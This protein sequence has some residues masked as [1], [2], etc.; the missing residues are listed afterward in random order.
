LD[1]PDQARAALRNP[2][3]DKE[4]GVYAGSWFLVSGFWFLVLGSWFV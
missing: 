2:A 3:Q 1:F 4:G